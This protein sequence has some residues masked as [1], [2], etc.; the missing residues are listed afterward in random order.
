ML[1]KENKYIIVVVHMGV[2]QKSV[3]DAGQTFLKIL[4][5]GCHFMW[6]KKEYGVKI[7]QMEH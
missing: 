1:S 2:K 6:R 7:E 5:P 3:D 4:I